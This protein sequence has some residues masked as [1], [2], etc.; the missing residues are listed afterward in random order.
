MHK[1]ISFSD[2]D[3]FASQLGFI[4][5]IKFR[6][7]VF[8]GFIAANRRLRR[9][10]KAKRCYYGPFKGEF[11]HMTAHTAPFLMYLHKQGVEIIYCGME[12]HKPLLVDSNRNSILH[13]F[14]P[15]RDFFPEVSPRGNSTEP[16][17]D[18]KAEIRKF[19][20]EANA[21][22]LPFWNIGDNFY[23]WFIHRNWLLEGHT[24]MY[25]LRKAYGT[26]EENSACI[27][28]RSKGAKFAK[29]N[30][31]RWDYQEVI[32]TLKPHFDKIYICGHP[33]QCESLQVSG[34]VE[35]CV[36]TD[37]SLMLEKCANSK[38][39][40][41]QHSGINNIGEFVGTKVLII[42]KGGEKID[43]VGSIYNT[44]RFRPSIGKHHPLSFAFSLDEIGRFAREF[45]ENGYRTP[46]GWK[47]T[48]GTVEEAV[49]LT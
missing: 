38:L 35:L 9:T 19:E 22:G 24:Y 25:D 42:Y 18:V 6:I 11:G 36:S 31:E 10:L 44:L 32:E 29:N 7:R 8:F 30:G 40:V 27:F 33:S 17:D 2:N 12:L 37:N 46:S 41:T 1:K 20:N 21:S 23:Y 5:R 15:L 49:R 28:P 43:D 39:I 34:N 14:R 45:R 16:P 26:K 48:A 13:E 47:Q 3:H 4:G